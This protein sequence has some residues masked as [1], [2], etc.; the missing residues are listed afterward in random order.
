MTTSER[1]TSEA[2]TYGQKLIAEAIIAHFGEQP[3]V[4][5]ERP[6][7]DDTTLFDV[8]EAFDAMLASAPASPAI[9]A[10]GVLREVLIQQRCWILHWLDDIAGNLKPTENS[11]RAALAVV[12]QELESMEPKT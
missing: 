9:G 11:L 8:W 2:W 5:D 4:E 1:P 6:A 12:E 10:R 3:A 7:D